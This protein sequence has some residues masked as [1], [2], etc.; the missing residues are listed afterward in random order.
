MEHLT[1]NV[2][3]LRELRFLKLR[4]SLQLF[5]RVIID[6]YIYRYIPISRCFVVTEL[7]STSGFNEAR[8]YIDF[9]SRQIVALYRVSFFFFLA[10]LRSRDGKRAS[11]MR[12]MV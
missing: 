4:Y 9:S 12:L 1:R 10:N 2:Y 7:I 11:T 8:P 5:P 3:T 6:T